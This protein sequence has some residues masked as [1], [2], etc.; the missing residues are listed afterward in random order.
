[1]KP[2][3][4]F[5]G[6]AV[7]DDGTI[8][9]CRPRNGLGRLKEQYKKLK[10]SRMKKTGHLYVRLRKNGA[11]HK[12][13]V[14]RL[15]LESFRGKCPK[16]LECRH[17][18]G[19]PSNNRL[20][21]LRWGTRKQNQSDRNKHGTS[22][23]GDRNGQS[24]LTFD[25]VEGIRKRYSKGNTTQLTLAKEFGISEGAVSKIVNFKSYPALK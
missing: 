11:H 7:K 17:L 10:P 15:V 24:K 14:H 20:G 18:D 1:M 25:Q 22:N 8:W 12:R 9:T 6:Y 5:P 2:I 16:G 3:K 23:H 4:N 21:N 19:N 13:Y